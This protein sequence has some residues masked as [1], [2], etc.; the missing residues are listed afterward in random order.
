MVLEQLLLLWVFLT[1][2]HVMKPR[3]RRGPFPYQQG[4]I[5]NKRY[6][7]EIVFSNVA[8]GLI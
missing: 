5:G 1:G 6:T 4:L 3:Y 8:I 7:A 2:R